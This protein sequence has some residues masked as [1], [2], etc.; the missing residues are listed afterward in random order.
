M[1]AGTRMP[2]APH[3]R[4]ASGRGAG[5]AGTGHVSGHN[6]PDA[7][8]GTDPDLAEIVRLILGPPGP[9]R[10]AGRTEAEA[11]IA[12]NIRHLACDVLDE[13]RS[14]SASPKLRDGL[15]RLEAISD[16]A[17]QLARKLRALDDTS[18]ELLKPSFPPTRLEN[19]AAQTSA[20][21]EHVANVILAWSRASGRHPLECI[22]RAA[23]EARE[24]IEW[25][26]EPKSGAGKKRGPENLHKHIYGDM[27][28]HLAYEVGKILACS[29][30][31]SAI[32]STE[33]GS[34]YKL[35]AAVWSYTTGLDAE[36]ASLSHAV[37]RA[38]PAVRQFMKNLADWDAERAAGKLPE[39]GSVLRLETEPLETLH[40]RRRFR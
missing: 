38:A 10:D 4:T 23:D 33:G 9:Q 13:L 15:D 18:L 16:L 29:R 31:I 22:A 17:S 40:G 5:T 6:L 36:Q 24:F 27:R 39:P 35:V 30:D 2:K 8:P 12:G 11:R 26:A 19:D 37:K 21:A 14:R 28:R 25:R 20:S 7:P 34:L 3:A 1:E 32:T